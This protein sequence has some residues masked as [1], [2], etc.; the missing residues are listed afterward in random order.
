[1][2]ARLG[3]PTTGTAHR[4]PCD[5]HPWA[6]VIT[7]WGGPHA[8]THTKGPTVQGG[9]RPTK[10][11]LRTTGSAPHRDALPTRDK[12]TKQSDQSCSRNLAILDTLTEFGEAG[13]GSQWGG[14]RH[15]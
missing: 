3:H 5:N 13:G 15:G 12:K 7:E 2:S 1:M 6:D 9:N 8:V 4:P 14:R 10:I 11:K